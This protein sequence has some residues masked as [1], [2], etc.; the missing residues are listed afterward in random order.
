MT[1]SYSYSSVEGD[2]LVEVPSVQ[3]IS[4]LLLDDRHLSK[5]AL[6]ALEVLEFLAETGRPVRA[7]EVARALA[8]S[9]STADQLLKSLVSR[10]YLIFDMA[11]KRYHPSPRLLRFSSFLDDAYYGQHRLHA[12]MRALVDQTRLSVAVCT[13][14]GRLMQLVD[15]LMPPGSMYDRPAGHIFPL[16]NSAAGAA[17]L[18]DWPV[19]SVRNL[20]AQ[21]ADQLGPLAADPDTICRRLNEVRLNGHAFGGLRAES[22]KCSLAVALP[23][24][25]F[26]TELSLSLRGPAKWMV[27]NRWRLAALL[28]EAVETSLVATLPKPEKD[29]GEV[30]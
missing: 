12:L 2:D 27:A 9:P 7:F 17:L 14:F 23:T 1:I 18:A 13:P 19:R 21:S 11:T 28:E 29:T 5:S 30:N 3:P 15:V 22:E 20:I 6:R 26:G 25:A 10:A 8:L 16:F 24:A 4:E